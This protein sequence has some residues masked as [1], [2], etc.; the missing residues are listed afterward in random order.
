M[1]YYQPLFTLVGSGIKKFEQSKKPMASVMARGV[2]WIQ[3]GADKFEP[4]QNRVLIASGQKVR[5]SLV[6]SLSACLPGHIGN[7]CSHSLSL[8]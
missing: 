2:T 8:M 7:S 4:D 1:H 3:D 5:S 6:L